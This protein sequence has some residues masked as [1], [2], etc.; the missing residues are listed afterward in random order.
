MSDLTLIRTLTSD[1]IQYAAGKSIADG[2]KTEFRYPYAP[3]YPGTAKVRV[4][5]ALKTLGSDYTIDE[6]IGLITF[7]T[8][9]Q[10]QYVITVSANTTLLSDAQINEIL[11]Q[12]TSSS[13]EPVKLAAADCLD[14]IATS[15]ALIQKKIN[16]LDLQ[17]DGPAIADSMRKHAETLRK[18]VYD[19]AFAEPDFEIIEQ[20]NDKPGWDEKILKDFMRD[21]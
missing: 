2:E 13:D 12:Y 19:P 18:Q 3:I 6:S 4:N 5:G 10:N 14:V 16:I 15:E 21:S 11:G 17:T 1:S 9:P 7:N 8:P 20:I